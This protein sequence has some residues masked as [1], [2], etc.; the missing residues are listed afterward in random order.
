MNE[1]TRGG[2]CL[3]ADKCAFGAEGICPNCLITLSEECGEEFRRSD[4]PGFLCEGVV[5]VEMAIDYKSRHDGAVTRRAPDILEIAAL[6]I[7]KGGLSG[8]SDR[9]AENEYGAEVAGVYRAD[10][11]RFSAAGAL[12]AA[13][14]YMWGEESKKAERAIMAI[15]KRRSIFSW[16][17][18]KGLTK[19]KVISVFRQAR[20]ALMEEVE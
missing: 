20:R 19:E 11:V 7:E 6:L 13:T 10:A 12:H 18:K 8:N 16:S 3:I 17:R 2:K 5:R 14:P 1:K 9:L 15:T 4:T